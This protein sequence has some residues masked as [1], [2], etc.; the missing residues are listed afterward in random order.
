[1]ENQTIRI[2]DL[3]K[4]LET[5][6]V[7]LVSQIK[8]Q[9]TCVDT[10]V[11]AKF[12]HGWEEDPEIIKAQQDLLETYRELRPIENIVVKVNPE[13]KGLFYELAKTEF[14]AQSGIYFSALTKKTYTK[15][16]TP[17]QP[18]LTVAEPEE[19]ITTT[20]NIED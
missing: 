6:T 18:R 16:R 10:L 17:R 7:E 3:L 5:R 19:I 4:K 13:L 8:L 12:H 9:K 15:H 14:L 1:M 2:V 20:F 11:N